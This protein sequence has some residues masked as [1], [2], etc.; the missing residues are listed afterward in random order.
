ME[1]VQDDNIYEVSPLEEDVGPAAIWHGR[2][3]HNDDVNNNIVNE[4]INLSRFA[5]TVSENTMSPKRSVLR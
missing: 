5:G 1:Y 2:A 4:A 3:F